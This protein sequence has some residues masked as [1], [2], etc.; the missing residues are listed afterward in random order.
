MIVVLELGMDSPITGHG[1]TE[2]EAKEFAAAEALM[3]TNY[4]FTHLPPILSSK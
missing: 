2:I 4:R 1:K 3:K